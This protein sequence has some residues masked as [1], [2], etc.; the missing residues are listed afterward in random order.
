MAISIS[1]RLILSHQRLTLYNPKVKVKV[2]TI[3]AARAQVTPVAI[4]VINPVVVKQENSSTW[5]SNENKTTTMIRMR[6]NRKKEKRTKGKK[7][8]TR[9]QNMMKKTHKTFLTSSPSTTDRT[10]YTMTPKINLW[11]A[12]LRSNQQKAKRWTSVFPRR[13]LRLFSCHDRTN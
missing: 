8:K 6:I 3:K 10:N 4:Q 11:H 12:S 5:V 9:N 2:I 7:R 1:K 13:T